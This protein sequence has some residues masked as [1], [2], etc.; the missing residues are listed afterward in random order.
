[1]IP[2]VGWPEFLRTFEWRAGEHLTII[3][4]TGS[5]KS[6]LARELLRTREYSAVFG[7]KPRDASLRAFEDDGWT[8]IKSWPPPTSV[9]R[10]LLWPKIEKTADVAAL[11][12]VFAEALDAIYL[13][14][15]WAIWLDELPFLVGDRPPALRLREQLEL[16]WMQGRALGVSVGA[17]CQRPAHVPLLAYSQATWVIV[18]RATDDRDLRRL[19]EIGGSID[20]SELRDVVRNL[21]RFA[22]VACHTPTGTA[23]ISRAPAP[24]RQ[25]NQ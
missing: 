11:R 6:F 24:D 14:G 9:R 20:K 15:A 12:P 5:G 21:P 2:V 22:F 8:R 18:F 3:G 4:D 1:M 19:T 13:E 25:A 17:A 23:M 10:A 7:S 16:L